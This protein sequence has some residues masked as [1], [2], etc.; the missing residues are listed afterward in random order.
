MSTTVTL[1]RPESAEL[2]D[3]FVA[4]GWGPQSRE[5]LE[6]SIRAYTATVCARM[7]PGRLVGYASVF[8]DRCLTT[9]FGEFVVHPEFRHQGI[10]KAMMRLVELHFPR[11]H[12]YVKALGDSVGFY[13]ALGFRASSAP[14][15]SMFKQPSEGG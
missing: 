5:V 11:A 12:I 15:T 6:S 3:L 14:V 2:A 13:R 1:E 9:M 7:P 4:V 8:S 10:G